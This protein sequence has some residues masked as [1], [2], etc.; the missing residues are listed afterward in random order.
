MLCCALIG[1]ASVLPVAA[2]EIKLVVQYAPGGS[3][4]R[5]VRML[6]KRMTNPKYS[7]RVEYKTGAAGAIG[8][9]YVASIKTPGETAVLLASNNFVSGP[10][11]QSNTVQY[12]MEKDF[13]V[14]EYM[15]TQPLVVVAR[16]STGIKNWKDF[17]EYSKKNHMPYASSG[18][19]GSGHLVSAFVANSIKPENFTHIPYKGLPWV[20][21]LGGRLAFLS[22]GVIVVDEFVKEGKLVPIAVS[23]PG[24]IRGYEKVPTLKELKVNDYQL[25]RW[26]LAV[27][28]TSADPE[29]LKYVQSVI[30]SK[31]FQQDLI[32]FG[33]DMTPLYKDLG[34][35]F[36]EEYKKFQ[37]V[38]N[39]LDLREE[40]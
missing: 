19:N 11:L 5:V 20:D 40:K 8:H 25:Y 15:G 24:R 27:S 28:N 3:A 23:G 37:R 17:V 35:F 34:I 21:L 1:I 2:K 9:N 22:D 4:D 39:A 14:I 33:F 6:E 32:D 38:A 30:N 31:E 7:V 29:A 10:I 16:A 12:D 13:K 36:K 26:Y 18:T